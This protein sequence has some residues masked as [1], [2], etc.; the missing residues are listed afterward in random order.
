MADD[1]VAGKVVKS[2]KELVETVLTDIAEKGWSLT[3]QAG[4]PAIPGESR[5]EQQARL[6]AEII[7]R[8]RSGRR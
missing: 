8:M 3:N 1:S 5:I 6:A 4:L 7:E 2:E